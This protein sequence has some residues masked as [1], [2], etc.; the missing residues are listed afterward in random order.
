MSDQAWTGK[1]QSSPRVRGRESSTE[2]AIIETIKRL[3]SE[4]Q[5]FVLARCAFV[6]VGKVLGITLSGYLL[7]GRKRRIPNG[8]SFY[9]TVLRTGSLER[10]SPMRSLTPGFTHN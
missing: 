6:S 8:S 1:C 9:A 2:A 7:S 3:P 10:S 5:Q 4:I